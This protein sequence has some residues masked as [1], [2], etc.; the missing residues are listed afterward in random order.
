[1]GGMVAAEAAAAALIG[2][3]RRGRLGGIVVAEMAAEAAAEALIG[4][5]RRRAKALGIALGTRN[6]WSLSASIETMI[7]SP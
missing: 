3:E 6:S 4:E 5:E 1:M 2:G 7:C